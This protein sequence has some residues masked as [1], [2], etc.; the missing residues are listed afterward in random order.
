MHL[1]VD[2]RE[3]NPRALAP[4]TQ[5]RFHCPYRA[6]APPADA[7]TAPSTAAD[8]GWLPGPSFSQNHHFVVLHISHSLGQQEP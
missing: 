2:L 4:K 5:E 7:T 3:T 6:P 8:G 1:F